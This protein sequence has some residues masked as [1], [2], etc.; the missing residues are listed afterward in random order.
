MTSLSNTVE[1]SRHALRTAAIANCFSA[2]KASDIEYRVVEREMDR[3]MF[4]TML[5]RASRTRLASSSW[6]LKVSRQHQNIVIIEPALIYIRQ[7][8]QAEYPVILTSKVG[9][10]YAYSTS[11]SKRPFGN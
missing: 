11:D 10:I 7:R 3:K 5:I 6:A 9:R 4:I 8:V 2:S 1:V